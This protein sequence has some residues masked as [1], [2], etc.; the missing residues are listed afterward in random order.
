[1]NEYLISKYNSLMQRLS[2]LP[3]E[4]AIAQANE[5]KFITDNGGW[6][7]LG[8][9]DGERKIVV[10]NATGGHLDLLV[11]EFSAIRYAA[12]L[13]GDMLRFLA[14]DCRNIP[15]NLGDNNKVDVDGAAEFPESDARNPQNPAYLENLGL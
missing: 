11:N 1:M 7:G 3:E 6:A 12:S 2:D 5:N 15:D 9:N 8:K 4:I 10:Q 13:H 14:A